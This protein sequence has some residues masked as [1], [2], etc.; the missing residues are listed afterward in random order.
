MAS[1][2]L[3]EIAEILAI[4]ITKT[5][6]EKNMQNEQK[7]LDFERESSEAV[8]RREQLEYKNE[9]NCN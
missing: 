2:I 8:A 5:L 7:I 1:K 3:N 9:E 4:S 6:Y